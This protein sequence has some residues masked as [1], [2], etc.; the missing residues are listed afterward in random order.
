MVREKRGLPAASYPACFARLPT[1]WP[2]SLPTRNGMKKRE[3]GAKEQE[4]SSKTGS[5]GE[6]PFLIMSSISADHNQIEENYIITGKHSAETEPTVTEPFS[7]S[8]PLSYEDTME[9]KA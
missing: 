7:T 9:E 2:V 6:T 3:W 5:L 4:K 1:S 8:L